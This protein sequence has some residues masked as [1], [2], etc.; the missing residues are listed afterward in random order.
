MISWYKCGMKQPVARS[1]QPAF[2]ALARSNGTTIGIEY[3]DDDAA[4]YLSTQFSNDFRSTVQ[5]M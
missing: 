1:L 4:D 2:E 5:P 3:H